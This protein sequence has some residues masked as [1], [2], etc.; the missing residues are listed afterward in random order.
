LTYT[1]SPGFGIIYRLGEVLRV[2]FD[3]TYSK[4]YDGAETE[5]TIYSLRTKYALSDFVNLTIR[6]DQEISRAPDYKLTDITGN[7]EINL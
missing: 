2:D 7:V 6:G 1:L 5:I 4:S 3:Y